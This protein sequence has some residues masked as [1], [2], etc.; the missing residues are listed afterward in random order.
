M[1]QRQLLDREALRDLL[2]RCNIAGDRGDLKKLSEVF[3]EEAVL[4][5]PDFV[6]ETRA[7]IE[8]GLARVGSVTKSENQRKLSFLRHNLT[9]SQIDFL[10]TTLAKGRTYF[11]VVTDVGLDH[12]GVYVDQFAKLD[13]TWLISRREVRVDYRAENSFF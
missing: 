6:L 5:T 8:N 4:I 13:G 9:T 7:G 12:T 11:H 10:S 2:A 3:T 1:E